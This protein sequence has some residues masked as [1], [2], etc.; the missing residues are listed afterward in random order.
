[1]G[2]IF[3]GLTAVPKRPYHDYVSMDLRG[4]SVKNKNCILTI[5]CRLGR[6]KWE[7][8]CGVGHISRDSMDYVL[9]SAL[10]LCLGRRKSAQ[11]RQNWVP[12]QYGLQARRQKRYVRRGPTGATTHGEERTQIR[13]DCCSERALITHTVT[14]KPLE[15][16]RNSHEEDNRKRSFRPYQMGKNERPRSRNGRIV[17]L[18]GRNAE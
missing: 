8:L 11:N 18:D 3:C 15:I 1:M 2:I 12:I 9:K 6:I 5:S 14:A 16:Q 17:I 13:L 10:F 4:D 7:T